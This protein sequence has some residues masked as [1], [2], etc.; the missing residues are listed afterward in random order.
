MS[1]NRPTESALVRYFTPNFKNFHF[2]K[3]YVLFFQSITNCL[4]VTG[5]TD[6]VGFSQKK[7]G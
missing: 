1:S 5:V 7:R 4:P 2:K 3:K 6:L